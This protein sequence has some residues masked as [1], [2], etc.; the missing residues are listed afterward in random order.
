VADAAEW[1][2]AAVAAVLVRNCR[3]SRGDG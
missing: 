2:V 1:K 3:R